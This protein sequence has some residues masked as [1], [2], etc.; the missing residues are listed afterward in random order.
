MRN[1]D[2]FWFAVQDITFAFH[3]LCIPANLILQY[4]DFDLKPKIYI[5]YTYT[6]IVIR[7]RPDLHATC[8]QMFS[9]DI[10]IFNDNKI[11]FFPRL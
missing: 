3:R 1:A 8:H 5:Y 10:N 7:I 6:A 2:V 9:T 4:Y 11:V